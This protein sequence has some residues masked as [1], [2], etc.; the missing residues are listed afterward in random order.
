MTASRANG[1]LY[2]CIKGPFY[3]HGLTVSLAWICNY[4]YYKSG[5]YFPIPNFNGTTVE[6]WEWINNF[7]MHF[8]G[9]WLFIHANIKVKPC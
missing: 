2:V 6:V 3:Q 9:M 1:H 5:I 7:I 8:T 4:I